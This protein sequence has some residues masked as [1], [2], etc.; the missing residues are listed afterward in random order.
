MPTV[1]QRKLAWRSPIISCRIVRGDWEGHEVAVEGGD[2]ARLGSEDRV[3]IITTKKWGVLWARPSVKCLNPP[4]HFI[5]MAKEA[6]SV[7]I[8]ITQIGETEA[9]E[10]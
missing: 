5:V 2:E 4:T 9:P 8:P 7:V 10:V 1:W 6:S 3:L